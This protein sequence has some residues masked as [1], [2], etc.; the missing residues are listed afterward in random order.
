MISRVTALETRLDTI[1]PTLATKADLADVRADLAK[2][3]TE[4]HKGFGDVVRWI[5][6][7]GF[8]AVALVISAM[9][10]LQKAAPTAPQQIQQPPII[11]NV[12]SASP[13]PAPA[14]PAAKR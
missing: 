11:I 12:P 6:G 7:A 1:L 5:I 2:Q 4:F 10:F 3:S 9:T 14:A 13:A 8:T